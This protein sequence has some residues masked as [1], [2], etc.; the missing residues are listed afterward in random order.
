M[1]RIF[2]YRKR[3]APLPIKGKKTIYNNGVENYCCRKE[4]PLFFADQTKIISPWEA[5][6]HLHAITLNSYSKM[7]SVHTSNY[8]SLKYC[9]TM[10]DFLLHLVRDGSN[11]LFQKRYKRCVNFV[12][13]LFISLHL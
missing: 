2:N 5:Y 4:L 6:V 12:R 1:K 11:G 3:L 13:F 7:E 9:K 10:Q 8:V